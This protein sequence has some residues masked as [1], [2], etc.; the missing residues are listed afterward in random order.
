MAR[1][2]WVY[3]ACPFLKVW[4]LVV[5][6]LCVCLFFSFF[7]ENLT[8]S[9]VIN[10]VFCDTITSG[11]RVMGLVTRAHFGLPVKYRL[12][13]RIYREIPSIFEPKWSPNG[14]AVFSST[15]S[16]LVTFQTGS[17]KFTLLHGEADFHGDLV[18]G[19]DTLSNMYYAWRH[20]VS[21]VHRVVR[22]MIGWINILVSLISVMMWTASARYNLIF[23]FSSLIHFIWYM[24]IYDCT[25]N[26][27]SGQNEIVQI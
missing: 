21:C 14:N 25:L 13:S 15:S 19:W 16:S 6:S 17:V 5:A 26:E 12:F 8:L 10:L 2:G 24:C 1:L 11:D 27:Y 23:Y 18:V 22:Q 4:Y 7:G 3:K 20:A 9:E